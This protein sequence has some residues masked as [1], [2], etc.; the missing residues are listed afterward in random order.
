[1]VKKA[2][3]TIK[4]RIKNRKEKIEIEKLEKGENIGKAE[5]AADEEKKEDED[6]HS[7]LIPND[8]KK[9]IA[10]PPAE[11]KPENL[12]T[13]TSKLKKHLI[14]NLKF[15][16][17]FFLIFIVCILT[18]LQIVLIHIFKKSF[19]QSLIG[20]I[21]RR[22]ETVIYK[23]CDTLQR[24][25]LSEELIYAPF[26]MLILGT[27]LVTHRS[28]RFTNYLMIKYKTFFGKKIYK[29]AVDVQED[30]RVKLL[31]KKLES[32]TTFQRCRYRTKNSCFCKF[33]CCICC[34]TCCGGGGDEAKK[35]EKSSTGEGC[36]APCC[37]CCEPILKTDCCRV[38]CM[39][40]KILRCLLCIDL[41]CCI[42]GC[43]MEKRERDK[44]K[45]E[46]EEKEE[47][48]ENEKKQETGDLDESLELTKFQFK[49]PIP[50]LPY[51]TTNRLLST[52]VYIA[53]TYDILNIFMY[54]NSSFLSIPLTPFLTEKNGVLKDFLIQIL[55]VVVIGFKFYP[56]LAVADIEPHIATYSLSFIY[57]FIMWTL[58]MFNKGFCS[59]TEA[60]VKFSLEQVENQIHNSK[61][62]R[63][64][65]RLNLTNRINMNELDETEESK[66]KK[67]VNEKIPQIFDKF[68][69][70]KSEYQGIT[71]PS[72]MPTMFTQTMNITASR[73]GFRKKI[74]NK[75][76]GYIT[77]VLDGWSDEK[78]TDWAT[79]VRN[80]LEN[81]P[82][83]ISLSFL[84]ARFLLTLI[85]LLIKSCEHYLGKCAKDLSETDQKSFEL[86]KKAVLNLSSNPISPNFH[87]HICDIY[88]KQYG[89]SKY[90]TKNHNY[91]YVA[92]YITS[93]IPLHCDNPGEDE[94]KDNQYIS[95][96]LNLLYKIYEPVRHF[97]F[98]KQLI[99][100]YMV[101]F[102]L[103]Y[104]FTVF[105]VRTSSVFGAWFVRSLQVIFQLLFGSILPS[106]SFQ[107]HNLI[108]EFAAACVITSLI[109]YIQLLA[110]IKS[111]QKYVLHLHRGGELSN[112]TI[113]PN[114]NSRD[115]FLNLFKE[116]RNPCDK[117]S[118]K[119]N[120]SEMMA[121]H[122]LHYPG[123][124]IAHLV[125]AYFLMFIAIFIVIIVVKLVWYI[126][127]AFEL[128]LQIFLPVMILLLLRLLTIKFL[129]RNVFLKHD[130]HFISNLTPYF[131]ISYFNFFFDCFLGFVACMNRVWQT[132]IVSLFYLPRLDKTMFNE[133]ETLLLQQLDKGHLAY[134]N[135]VHMEH[136]YNN[137]VLISFTE[138]LVEMM[139]ISYIRESKLRR[140]V[141]NKA[142]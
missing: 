74:A 78:E 40:K 88:E 141:R 66:Y 115:L 108:F 114:V 80:L 7:I 51:S 113:D 116:K 128:I 15:Y 125:Y 43:I 85:Q 94:D 32:M 81:L 47:K 16:D 91:D 1:M 26:A 9:S 83:Y 79:T 77:D 37:C 105:I 102:M 38:L 41:W 142:K 68:F 24:K 50:L 126:P 121:S 29:K 93:K 97:R 8:R 61:I 25:Y 75:T 84:L 137:P 2:E 103:I 35:D 53:Y 133:K 86:I 131:V 122:S 104:F 140:Y 111:F 72:Y 118:K 119:V 127:Q 123:Y 19:T 5:G 76:L 10:K 22:N 107:E 96:T 73:S 136:L 135:F 42:R 99:N 33:L 49:W 71:T 139:F 87:H 92:M 57:V 130:S 134:M 36:S 82:L 63:W 23:I 120:I 138:I 132:T 12:E 34:C 60:F 56:I 44:E 17:G 18:A 3:K 6:K 65:D 52:A 101:A 31:D 117:E 62:F 14:S 13:L 45:K 124:L 20:N 48:E 90:R 129:T 106:F 54:L 69:G 109:S 58:K 98:S 64:N 55:Q 89:I 46:K 100:T 28:A 95:F 39:I 4:K 112:T 30:K 70:P 21:V 67:V 27:I 11:P 110:S 59:R